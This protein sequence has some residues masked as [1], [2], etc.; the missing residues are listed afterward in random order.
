MPPDMGQEPIIVDGIRIEADNPFYWQ[1]KGMQQEME[2]METDKN[3]F[4]EPEV[5][6][7][8]LSIMEEEIKLYVNFAKNIVKPTD[9]RVELAWRSMQYVHDKFIYEHN[10]VPEDKLLEAVMYRM[11]WIPKTLRRNISIS[12]RKKNW[13]LLT[14]WKTS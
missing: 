1:I 8:V 3:R 5:L 14:N 13:L 4:S 7:L 2:A 9:Y 12:L 6:D 11:V 10:D